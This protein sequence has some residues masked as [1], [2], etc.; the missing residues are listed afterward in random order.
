MST[1]ADATPLHPTRP[2]KVGYLL[3]ETEFRRGPEVARWPELRAMAER[4]EA[5][6][7]DSLWAIDRLLFPAGDE[8]MGFPNKETHGGWEAWSLMAGLAAVTARVELGQL[9]TNNL[10]RNPALLAKMAATV[11]EI[12]N[13][14]L[15]LSLGAGDGGGDA[16]MFGFAHDHRVDRFAE[17]IEI[18]AGLLREGRIDFEGRYYRVREGELR[19]RGPRPEGPPILIGSQL[20]PRMLRLVAQHADLWNTWIPIAPDDVAT[21]LAPLDAACVAIGRDPA[22]LGRTLML[23]V[24][25]PGPRQHPPSTAYGADRAAE[26][27]AGTVL[28][29][30]PAA[31]AER[32]RAY[33][34]A[35]I[36]HVIVHLDPDT[37]GGIEAFAPVLALL[38]EGPADRQFAEPVGRAR[39]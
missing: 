17:A 8:L 31:I 10:F 26:V 24:D 5:V 35:G 30:E 13:G 6:G 1:V 9:V 12:S 2:L 33:A 23:S 16:A 3:P 25:L 15:I 4:A 32:L 21:V 11:D 29:G 28:T 18:V 36:G 20:M 14:R 27:A 7:F 34:R 38:D 19:P 37:V 22:T 39:A